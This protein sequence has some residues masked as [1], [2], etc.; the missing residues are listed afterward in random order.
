MEDRSPA[1]LPSDDKKA[2]QELISPAVSIR[3]KKK[4]SS[5]KEILVEV[6]EDP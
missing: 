2:K 3:R 6:E 4:K 5:K 1:S